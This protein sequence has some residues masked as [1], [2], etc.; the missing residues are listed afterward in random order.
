MIHS[1]LY[2]VCH[3]GSLLG[4]VSLQTLPIS[5]W[6]FFSF[7]MVLSRWSCG[8]CKGFLPS[9]DF[10]FSSFVVSLSQTPGQKSLY[11]CFICSGTHSSSD[12]LP[13][14]QAGDIK[15]P[16]LLTPTRGDAPSLGLWSLQRASS[17]LTGILTLGYCGS[18]WDRWSD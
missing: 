16:C 14:T 4:G 12:V 2:A 7:L 18:F 10:S 5:V 13:P 6:V 1:S 8:L 3:R 15:E 9:C 11:A 17:D